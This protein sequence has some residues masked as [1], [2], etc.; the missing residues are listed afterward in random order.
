M[1]AYHKIVLEKIAVVGNIISVALGPAGAK[2]PPPT[3]AYDQ[4]RKEQQAMICRAPRLSV[5]A[6]HIVPRGR[7]RTRHEELAEARHWVFTDNR[8][9]ARY[10]QLQIC[11]QRETKNELSVKQKIRARMGGPYLHT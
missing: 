11:D 10:K 6:S 3:F 2:N 1:S 9:G 5:P 8:L 7:P 4:S